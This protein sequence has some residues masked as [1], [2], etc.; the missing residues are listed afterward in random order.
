MYGYERMKEDLNKLEDL[1]TEAQE[2]CIVNKKD[3]NNIELK[4]NKPFSPQVT[5]YNI[6]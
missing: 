4:A 1:K 5:G 3:R 2:R 6:K